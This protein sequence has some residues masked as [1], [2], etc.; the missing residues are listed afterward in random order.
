MEPFTID[1]E[2]ELLIVIG[3]D[4]SRLDTASY[5][6]EFKLFGL[7]ILQNLRTLPRNSFSM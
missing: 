4:I 7:R 6:V 2:F 1:K 3:F 5:T